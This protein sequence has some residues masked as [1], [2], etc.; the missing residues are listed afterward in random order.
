M[1]SLDPQVKDALRELGRV[2]DVAG[3]EET[4]RGCAKR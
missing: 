2:S 3:A 1:A 4:V